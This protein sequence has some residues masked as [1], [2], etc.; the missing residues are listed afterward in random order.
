MKF[1]LAKLNTMSNFLVL[2]K[3]DAFSQGKSKQVIERLTRSGLQIKNC[4]TGVPAPELVE[5]HYSHLPPNILKRN[6]E[7]LCSG[8]VLKLEVEGDIPHTRAVIGNTDPSK[9]SPGTIRGDFS[10]DSREHADLENRGIHNLVHASDSDENGKIELALWG[11][12]PGKSVIEQGKHILKLTDEGLGL[13]EPDLNLVKTVLNGTENPII[14]L[15]FHL[16]LGVILAGRYINDNDWTAGVPNV[17]MLEDGILRWKGVPLE[18]FT[19]TAKQPEIFSQTV[20]A[21]AR[22][23]IH[24]ESVGLPVNRRTFTNN[25]LNDVNKSF[26]A[27]QLQFLSRFRDPYEH[28]DG[29]IAFEIQSG[30]INEV[31]YLQVDGSQIRFIREQV[32]ADGCAYTVLTRHGFELAN[33]GATVSTLATGRQVINWATSK[34]LDAAKMQR[35]LDLERF[36]SEDSYA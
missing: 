25:W 11:N 18:P 7:F 22:K 21:L 5:Q 29:R 30:D 2:L 1:K 32:K 17:T 14:L 33:C 16:L 15:K 36:Y 26:T 34:K 28:I 24:L 9:A 20:A 35:L 12:F 31:R 27:V 10:S 23:C 6:V 19:A 13:H 8:P 4:S 3:P